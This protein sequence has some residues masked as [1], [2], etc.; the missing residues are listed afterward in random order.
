VADLHPDEV[1]F[2]NILDEWP[3][4]WELRSVYSDWLEEN[5][6]L[7]EAEAQRWMSQNKRHPKKNTY[8][9]P[10]YHQ[11]VDWDWT[12]ALDT[13]ADLAKYSSHFLPYHTWRFL[14]QK[15]GHATR[16]GAE[17]ELAQALQRQKQHG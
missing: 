17:T 4:D 12:G 9:P 5:G 10:G 2:H 16:H 13:Q 3:D 6:R 14:D 7:P 15:I 11:V 1:G 8:G